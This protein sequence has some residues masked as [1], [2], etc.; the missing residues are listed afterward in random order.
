MEA[1]GARAVLLDVPSE[2]T[3][4]VDGA[5]FAWDDRF[6]GVRNVPLGIHFLGFVAPGT[7][8]NGAGECV[9][10]FIEVLCR[11]DVF[12]RRWDASLETMGAGEGM[13]EAEAENARAAARARAFD[14]RMARY[15]EEASKSWTAMSGFITRK[16]LRRCGIDCGTRIEA[17][18]PDA[19]AREAEASGM[20]PYFDDV[21]RAPVFTRAATSRA[22]RGKT[23]SEISALNLD[24]QLRLSHA[25]E[26]FGDDGWRGLMGEFQLAFVLLV[27]L[28][29][30]AALEQWKHLAHVV[31]ACA[32]SAVFKYPEL[33]STFIDVMSTQLERAGEDFFVDDYSDDNF[34]RPCLVALMKIDVSEAPSDDEITDLD[35]RAK[36][37]GIAKKLARL[38]RDVRKKFDVRL[39][40]EAREAKLADAENENGDEDGPVVVELSEGTYMAMNATNIDQDDTEPPLIE[41]TSAPPSRM[42][43]MVGEQS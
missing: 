29:S 36:L 4:R 23:P 8:A 38:A 12:V 16:S 31:C 10:E 25:L 19:D 9:G 2:A 18:D 5:E 20:T 7:D 39:V 15:P 21:Q 1:G 22:P 30:M 24:P 42:S 28:S 37:D 32:Q 35:Q 14:G 34:I 27:G 13:A 3:A 40:D 6:Q 43:W 26:C 41:P 11:D 17:G 33:Y